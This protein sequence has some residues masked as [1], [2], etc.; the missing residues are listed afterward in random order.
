MSPE[1]P[2]KFKYPI[3]AASHVLVDFP[4]DLDPTEHS[5]KAM[6]RLL[7]D[8]ANLLIKY[9]WKATLTKDNYGLHWLITRPNGPR[10]TFLVTNTGVFE[11]HLVEGRQH[12]SRRIEFRPSLGYDP[13]NDVMMGPYEWIDDGDAG[14][15]KMRD[16]SKPDVPPV[17]I[18]ALE[19]VVSKMLHAMK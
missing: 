16:L 4:A 14:R 7:D 2:H 15:R 17:R 1:S 3:E 6:W 19:H 11:A 12:R 8:A 18:G 10:F 13:I 5:I 9:G